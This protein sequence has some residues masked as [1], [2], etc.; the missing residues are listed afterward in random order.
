MAANREEVL[1]AEDLTVQKVPTPGWGDG[2]VYVRMMMGDERD[3]FDADTMQGGKANLKN[4]RGRFAA[5]IMC[6]EQGKRLFTDAD[7]PLLGKKCSLNLDRI[8]D[9]GG[10]LNGLHQRDLEESVK[11]SASGPSDDSG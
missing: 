4:A 11:N 10:S 7:A 3:Q 2:H 5:L 1:E 6:D 9:V 8:F